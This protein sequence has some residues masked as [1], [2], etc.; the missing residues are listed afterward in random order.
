MR[1]PHAIAVLVLAFLWT[2]GSA[3]ANQAEE[4][5]P[6]ANAASNRERDAR[7]DV[8]HLKSGRLLTGFRVVRAS[9]SDFVVEVFPGTTIRIP[10]GQVSDV[11]FDEES[12]PYQRLLG[13]AAETP[14]PSVLPG[15]RLSRALNAQL[16]SPVTQETIEYERADLVTVL[17]AINDELDGVIRVHSSVYDLSRTERLWTVELTPD[18]TLLEVLRGKLRQ[19]FPDLTVV[20]QF[21]YVL[22]GADDSLS[23]DRDTTGDENSSEDSTEPEPD[24]ARG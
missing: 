24:T 2:E 11:E 22:I 13:D 12:R 8:I 20:Y 19:D 14:G 1:M 10:R 3:W 9:P 15:T 21:D 18:H 7:G 16:N 6:S 23:T 4:G 5:E 17:N